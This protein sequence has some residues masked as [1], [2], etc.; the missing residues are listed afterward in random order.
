MII[1]IDK[2]Y[3]KCINSYMLQPANNERKNVEIENRV[4]TR[5]A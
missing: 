1:R 4:K 5:L 3:Q 2:V